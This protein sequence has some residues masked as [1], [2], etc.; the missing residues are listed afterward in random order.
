M[1]LG[2]DLDGV[3]ADFNRGWMKLYNE[4]F[5]T[6]LTPDLVQRWNGIHRLTHLESMQ[7]F[8]S[9]ARGVDRPSVFRHLPTY[10]GALDTLRVLAERHDIVIVT[11]KPGWAVHDTYAWISDVRIPTREIHVTTHKWHVSCDVYLEDS[12]YQLKALVEH[13]PESTVCR[14]VRPWNGPVDGAR[15]V[16]GWEDFASVV[17]ELAGQGRTPLR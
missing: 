2:I 11:T 12:P 9:W 13:R 10:E 5:G 4:E 1:R 3:V 17:R 16:A 8:W 6:D 7:D 14:Y 15:D